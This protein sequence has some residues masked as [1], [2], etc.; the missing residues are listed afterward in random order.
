M[1]TD[2][3][4]IANIRRSL[5]AARQSSHAVPAPAARPPIPPGRAAGEPAAEIERLL[6]EINALA[7]SARRLPEAEIP[8]ALQALVAEQQI[9]KACLWQTAEIEALGIAAHLTALGVEIVAPTAG[10]HALAEC[11]LGVTGVDYALPATGTLALLSSPE[12]PRAVS[13]LPRVHLALLHPAAL[14]ADLA[15]VFAETKHAA[16]TIFITGP[17]RTSDIELTL[18]LG[19]HGPKALYAWLLED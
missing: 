9:H 19:V 4:V 5:A 16:Y 14:R 8:A 7:G 18:T 1:P 15:D 3:P 13:L 12:K 11:D 2:N 17:S 6:A 10:K